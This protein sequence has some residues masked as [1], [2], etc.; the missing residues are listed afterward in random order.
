[1]AKSNLTKKEKEQKEKI[2]FLNSIINEKKE[3]TKE[4]KGLI[5]HFIF[6]ILCSNIVL[7]RYE[8]SQFGDITKNKTVTIYD[9]INYLGNK[10]KEEE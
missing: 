2:E 10:I 3:F 9:C 1:M 4:Q 8:M 7:N 5:K 6:N